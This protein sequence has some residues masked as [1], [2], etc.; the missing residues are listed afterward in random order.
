MDGT[1]IFLKSWE[2]RK[3]RLFNL[4]IRSLYATETVPGKKE[5]PVAFKKLIHETRDLFNGYP[6]LIDFATEC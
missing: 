4:K 3:K 2:S 5:S 1:L 6:K